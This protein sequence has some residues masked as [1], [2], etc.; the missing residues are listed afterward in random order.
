CDRNV[1]RH[2]PGTIGDAVDA[3]DATRCIPR[4]AHLGVAVRPTFHQEV[5]APESILELQ[6]I[7][8]ACP[9][10]AEG[11]A[12]R[13][14]AVR[15]AECRGSRCREQSCPGAGMPFLQPH[16]EKAMG[17]VE[18][19]VRRP[20]GAFAQQEDIAAAHQ[21]TRMTVWVLAYPTVSL[22]AMS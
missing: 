7:D 8:Y 11:V 10:A 21:T 19:P 9:G 3:G 18:A 1:R 2:E 12:D 6:R 14:A 16:R 13:S 15:Q 20:C 4:D 5:L 17:D 22:R